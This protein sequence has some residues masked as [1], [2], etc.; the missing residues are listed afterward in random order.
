MEFQTGCPG[1]NPGSRRAIPLPICAT[2]RR[3]RVPPAAVTP[4]IV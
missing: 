2:H 1:G 3:G 4:R